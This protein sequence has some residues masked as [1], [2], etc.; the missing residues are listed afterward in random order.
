MNNS[1]AR[2]V[3][4]GCFGMIL[5]LCVGA[6]LTF[7]YFSIGTRQV[8]ET[9]IPV[10][11][12]KVVTITTSAA[13]INTQVQQVAKQ[14]NMLKQT[15]ATLDVPNLIKVA[16]VVDVTILGQRINTNAT[17]MMRVAVKSNKV[18]LSIDKIETGNVLVPQS[19]LNST[20][21][22]IRA[23]AETQINALVQ[24]GLQGTGLKLVN[25]RMTPGEMNI[26]L[27]AQ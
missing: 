4:I 19:L 12:D 7:G 24:R 18:A 27:S 25:I 14:T 17:V 3:L 5:G 16:T 26:D 15:T 21:E 22:N 11:S 20:V 1:G 2:N 8:I 6:G 23:Q 10:P 9:P 13:Y